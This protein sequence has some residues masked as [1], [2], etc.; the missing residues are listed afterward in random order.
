MAQGGDHGQPVAAGAALGVYPSQVSRF[1]QLRKLVLA[2]CGLPPGAL[3]RLLV[4]QAGAE[5]GWSRGQEG[6]TPSS[7]AA[8]GLA[9]PPDGWVDWRSCWWALVGNRSALVSWSFRFRHLTAHSA[10]SLCLCCCCS[11]WLC[12]LAS[13]CLLAAVGVPVGVLTGGCGCRVWRLRVWLVASRTC[14][15]VLAGPAKA[16]SAAADGD[17]WFFGLRRQR[18]L[19]EVVSGA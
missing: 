2:H 7:G 1:V 13:L 10:S 12:A 18:R 14:R 19:Q 5:L 6:L 9:A 4:R 16:D 17:G 11:P 8:E 3:T 15:E